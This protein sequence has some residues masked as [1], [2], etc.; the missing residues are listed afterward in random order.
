M[1]ISTKHRNRFKFIGDKAGSYVEM[2]MAT[3]V[4]ESRLGLKWGVCRLVETLEFREIFCDVHTLSTVGFGDSY[5]SMLL[6]CQDAFNIQLRHL[7]F[8][9]SINA[10]IGVWVGVIAALRF[11]F[12][13]TLR[14]CLLRLRLFL[15]HVWHHLAL[16]CLDYIMGFPPCSLWRSKLG[17]KYWD[18]NVHPEIV[19]MLVHNY[20]WSSW[21]WLLFSDFYLFNWFDLKCV[22]TW[23]DDSCGWI[24]SIHCLEAK[25]A[26]WQVNN[27]FI[28][29]LSLVHFSFL[30]FN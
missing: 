16:V 8:I 30:Q 17:A 26:R 27:I 20:F 1:W 21:L 15:K 10:F 2:A 28:P 3:L 9:L 19:T 13:A 7:V 11:Q 29:H 18:L 14:R 22:K 25:S 24:F 4:S 12:Y 23:A 5:C 6:L